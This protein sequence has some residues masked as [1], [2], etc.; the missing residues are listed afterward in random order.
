MEKAS[1]IFHRRITPRSSTY[2]CHC[3]SLFDAGDYVASEVL[4]NNN[5]S[6][7][8]QQAPGQ[9]RIRV[10]MLCMRYVVNTCMYQSMGA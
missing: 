3:T 1:D 5:L 7:V 10:M 2:Y 8:V 6:C 9:L 4:Y